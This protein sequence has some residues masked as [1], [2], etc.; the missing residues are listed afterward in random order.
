M[1]VLDIVFYVI[2]GLGLFLFGMQTMSDALK[3][4]ASDR[5]RRLLHMLT[6]NIVVGVLVGA[7]V[8]GVIQ[9]SGAT[10]V[11]VVGFVNAGLM[12]LKQAIGVIMGANIGT[13]VTAWLVSGLGVLNITSYALPAIGLGF[14]V[15]VAAKRQWKHWGRVLLGFGLLF[16][17]LMLLKDAF[18]PLGKSEQ[19]RHIVALM[20]SNPLYGVIIGTVMTILI[21]SSSATIAI[22]QLLA[23]QGVLSFSQALPFVFGDNIGTTITA[24]VA[25]IGT[26]VNARRAARAHLMFNVIGVVLLLP[27]VWIRVTPGG[28][29]IYGWFIDKIVPG[30]ADSP[31]A[32]MAHIAAGHTAFN[33]IN[34]LIWLPAAGWLAALV[35]WLVPGEAEVVQVEPQYLEEHLLNNPPIALEQARREVVRM[36]EL[37]ASAVHD[38]SEAFFNDD[39]KALKAVQ[40]KEEAID[41]LQN[42]ITQYLIQVS[43]QQLGPAESNELPALLHSVN[44][45][46]RIGDHAVNLMEAAERKIEAKLPFSQAAIIELSMMRTEVEAMFDKVVRALRSSDLDAAKAAFENEARLNAMQMQFRESHLRRLSAGDCRFESGLTFVDC[47]CYYEKI[48]DHLINVAQAV[49][50]DFQWG[51]KYRA[52]SFAA[53][54][55]DPSAAPPQPPA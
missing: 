36:V 17:G 44:D 26:S 45:I 53:A 4:V 10:T 41:N 55:A 28:M 43:R 21:Q 29:S 7:A 33:V 35:T 11:M 47:I 23:F 8:T 42:K 30:A 52:A 38:A 18:S 27:L 1:S 13:T 3:R 51:E 32:V 15:S 48:G 12:T 22:A 31:S 20:T 19:A 49:L 9:A 50:G 39:P 24:N 25:A 6:D 54:H 40:Q 46:E 16:F 5:L 34:T 2:G 37:A 14:V